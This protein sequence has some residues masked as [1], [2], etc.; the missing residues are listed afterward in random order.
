MPNNIRRPR[1]RQPERRHN[2]ACAPGTHLTDEERRR[3]YRLSQ[4]QGWSHRVIATTL[5]L[6]RTTV[7]S[8]IYAMSGKCRKEQ[9]LTRVLIT[10][11]PDSAP[12]APSSRGAAHMLPISNEGIAIQMGFQQPHLPHLTSATPF[13]PQIATAVPDD[14]QDQPSQPAVVAYYGGNH[15]PNSLSMESSDL[16]RFNGHEAC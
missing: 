13:I 8:A 5:Q 11:V 16:Q 10:P 15:Q 14:H 4:H 6:P 3:I 12:A 1:S 9:N 7:Q 2:R